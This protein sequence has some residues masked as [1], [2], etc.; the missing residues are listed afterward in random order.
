[1]DVDRA[2][3]QNNNRINIIN[4]NL[5]AQIVMPHYS[6]Y[7]LTINSHYSFDFQ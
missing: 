3:K 7:S 4:N 2:H 1:M 6:H 5:F